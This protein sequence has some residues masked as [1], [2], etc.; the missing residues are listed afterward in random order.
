MTYLNGLPVVALTLTDAFEITIYTASVAVSQ[1]TDFF[2][3]YSWIGNAPTITETG[4]TNSVF[5]DIS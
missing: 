5:S 3:F 1:D 2:I 4:P